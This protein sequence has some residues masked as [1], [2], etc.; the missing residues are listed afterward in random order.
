I[1]THIEVVADAFLEDAGSK[2]TEA[3]AEFYFEVHASLHRGIAGITNDAASAK[4]ARP[5]FHAAMKP[6]DDFALGK[7]LS[8]FV[9]K[10]EFVLATLVRNAHFSEEVRN[11]VV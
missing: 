10:S 4:G 6:T 5:E 8:H 1:A 2:G 11:K 7:Q 3:L 9:E